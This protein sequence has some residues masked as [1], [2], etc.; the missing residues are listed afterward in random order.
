MSPS[1]V[2]QRRSS[3]QRLNRT[4]S[5]S[6][7][8]STGSRTAGWIWSPEGLKSVWSGLGGQNSFLHTLRQG[9]R[10]KGCFWIKI[11]LAGLIDDPEQTLFLGA[12]IGERH[13]DLP[14]FK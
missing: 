14:F 5:R 7:A 1:C 3:A 8:A 11:G 12:C 6:L 9:D 4:S 10:A 2:R 13:I